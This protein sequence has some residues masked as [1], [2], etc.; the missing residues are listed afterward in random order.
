MSSHMARRY[1]TRCDTCFAG[2]MPGES[3]SCTCES[4]RTQL[5]PRVTPGRFSLLAFRRPTS[6]LMS[7]DLPTF[8]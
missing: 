4:I 1:A 2:M 5:K 8:G 7:A 6:R 3:S